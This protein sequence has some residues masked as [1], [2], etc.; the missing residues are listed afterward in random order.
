[1]HTHAQNDSRMLCFVDSFMI[2]MNGQNVNGQI[3]VRTKPF[4]EMLSKF[5]SLYSART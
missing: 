5:C 3:F 1:M 4:D 2:L